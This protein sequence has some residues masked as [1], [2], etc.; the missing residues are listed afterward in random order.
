MTHYRTLRVSADDQDGRNDESHT[1]RFGG[2]IVSLSSALRERERMCVRTR[3]RR[4]DEDSQVNDENYHPKSMSQGSQ[5]N[6]QTANTYQYQSLHQ[7]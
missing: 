4:M 7:T 2:M 1:E 3:S 5:S 6:I